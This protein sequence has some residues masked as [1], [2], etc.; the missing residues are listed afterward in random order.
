M[1]EEKR[2]EKPNPNPNAH[3]PYPSLPLRTGHDTYG[4]ALANILCA[5]EHGIT[6]VDTSVAGLGGC[7]F[8]GP[9]AAGNVATEDVVYMLRGLGIEVC[10]RPASLS[11]SI[12]L[13]T[14]LLPPR[15]FAHRLES[16]LT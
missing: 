12:S 15:P 16:I 13:Y 1:R 7:P 8:A 6:T 10:E 9:G 3:A 11:L 2:R 4:Q 14:A 5:L